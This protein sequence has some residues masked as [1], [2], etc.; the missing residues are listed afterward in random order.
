MHLTSKTVLTLVGHGRGEWLPA[1]LIPKRDSYPHGYFATIKGVPTVTHRKREPKLQSSTTG[2]LCPLLLQAQIKCEAA[3][4]A[5]QLLHRA[6]RFKNNRLGQSESIRIGQPLGDFST[7]QDLR[8]AFN[9]TSSTGAPP[10]RF[11]AFMHT[12]PET[13]RG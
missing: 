10:P 13:P 2:G 4:N 6:D 3:Q 11:C 1:S 9:Q 7:R 5:T 8:S 12:G